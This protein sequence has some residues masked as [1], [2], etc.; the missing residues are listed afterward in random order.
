MDGDLEVYGDSLAL[1]DSLGV[2]RGRVLLADSAGTYRL[3]G[4]AVDF[5]RE[6]EGGAGQIALRGSAFAWLS[7]GDSPLLVQGPA[8][9]IATDSAQLRT[10]IAPSGAVLHS[11]EVTGAADRLLWSEREG[12]VNLEGDPVLWSGTDQLTGRHGAALSA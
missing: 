2:A 11:D 12:Q 10:L 8:I 9:T 5:E 3:G 1:T 4:D 6:A 7:E